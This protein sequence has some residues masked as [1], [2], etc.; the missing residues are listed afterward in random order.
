MFS[1]ACVCPQGCVLS[2]DGVVPAPGGVSVSGGWVIAWSQ[3]GLVLGGCLLPG[4]VGLPARTEGDPPEEMATAADGMH[5]TGMHSVLLFIQCS[6][7]CV[8]SWI[9]ASVHYM[10]HINEGCRLDFHI[11]CLFVWRI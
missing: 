1:Q 2:Q 8:L 7:T 9:N 5:P 4:G 6:V 10:V 11:V 3:G